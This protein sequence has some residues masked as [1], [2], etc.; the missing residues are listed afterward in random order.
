[1]LN[2]SIVELRRA[3]RYEFGTLEFCRS[4]SVQIG[5]ALWLSLVMRSL[6]KSLGGASNLAVCKEEPGTPVSL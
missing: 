1:M 6:L 4:G 5:T 3:R 2:H